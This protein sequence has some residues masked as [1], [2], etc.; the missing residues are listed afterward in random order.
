MISTENETLDRHTYSNADGIQSPLPLYFF[1][2]RYTESYLR[3]MQSFVDSVENDTPLEVTGADG[4]APVVIGL[5]ARLS[6]DE[7]RPVSLKEI[8]P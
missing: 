3:E 4:R 6:Y 7:N 8:S 2:E 1:L 5:A